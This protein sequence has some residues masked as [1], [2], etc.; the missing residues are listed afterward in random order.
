[1][2]P[3]RPVGRPGQSEPGRPARRFGPKLGIRAAGVMELGQQQVVEQARDAGATRRG[4]ARARSAPAA[5]S[6]DRAAS[7]DQ[8][9]PRKRTAPRSGG[10]SPQAT[11]AS[12]CSCCS[13]PGCTSTRSPARTR[14]VD[15]DA[16]LVLVGQRQPD[17]VELQHGRRAVGAQSTLTRPLTRNTASTARMKPTGIRARSAPGSRRCSMAVRQQ[18]MPMAKPIP[19]DFRGRTA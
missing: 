11:S 4:A 17:A 6:P 3:G 7:A 8:A 15:R 14:E 5:R 2:S 10:T 18:T 16:E 9:R 12:S 1:M 13:S 19:S